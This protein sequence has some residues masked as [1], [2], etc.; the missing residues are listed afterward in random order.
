MKTLQVLL[1]KHTDKI[2]FAFNGKEAL[3]KVKEKP[4]CPNCQNKGYVIYFIDINMPV[5]DG[6]ETVRNLK[7]MMESREI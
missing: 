6:Y 4:L 1:K 3:E 7:R 2:D 5:M